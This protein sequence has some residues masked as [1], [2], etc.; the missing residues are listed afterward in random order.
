M[1]ET[2]QYFVCVEMFGFPKMYLM[3]VL[4]GCVL[5]GSIQANVEKCAEGAKH[6]I[7]GFGTDLQ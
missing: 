6:E 3:N 2:H 1:V 4:K 5:F 7:T